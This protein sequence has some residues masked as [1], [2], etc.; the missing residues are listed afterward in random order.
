MAGSSGF[1]TDYMSSKPLKTLVMSCH[2]Q[3]GMHRLPPIIRLALILK[4]NSFRMNSMAK[5][6]VKIMFK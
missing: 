5:T 1:N 3:K 2:V 6:P 4:A